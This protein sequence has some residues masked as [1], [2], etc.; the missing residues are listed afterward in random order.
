MDNKRGVRSAY[1]SSL[2]EKARL[3]YEAKLNF[4]G[5]SDDPYAMEKKQF[6]VD[7]S[8]WPAISYAD[9]YAYLVDYPQATGPIAA[10][11]LTLTLN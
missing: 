1:Y 10:K 11:D 2:D 3:R 8:N 6:D 7:I 4:N 5:L 9:V